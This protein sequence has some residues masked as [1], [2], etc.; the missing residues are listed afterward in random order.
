MPRINYK[1][2]IITNEWDG[3][4]AS[5]FLNGICFILLPIICAP[6]I[7]L[8]NSGTIDWGMVV[9]FLILGLISVLSTGLHLRTGGEEKPEGKNA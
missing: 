8:T 1:L 9:F 7:L 5:L 3:V 4:R 2:S 6:Y